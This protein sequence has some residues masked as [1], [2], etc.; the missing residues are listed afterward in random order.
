MAVGNVY[1]V[2][3]Q[4]LID[5]RK[6]TIAVDYRQAT[7][8]NDPRVP[9]TL[10]NEFNI[11]VVPD[12]VAALGNDV[13]FQCI[14]V[15]N[16]KSF[17]GVDPP[18][19]L[20]LSGVVGGQATRSINSNSAAVLR[21]L[22]NAA[23]QRH[24]GRIFLPGIPLGQVTDSVINDAFVTGTLQGA[25]DAMSITLTSA[26]PIA[27]DWEPV[28][29]QRFAGGVPTVPPITHDVTE[30]LALGVIYSQKRRRTKRTGIN[31]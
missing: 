25:I 24:N 7:G 13:A 26:I 2:Q 31:P 11:T 18:F 8:P 4:L 3:L 16:Q 6:C 5:N 23:D 28:V 21:Q 19:E 17:G 30:A 14:Y 10:A 9:E 20:A 15:R 29:I 1:N 22:T 27:V 12:I